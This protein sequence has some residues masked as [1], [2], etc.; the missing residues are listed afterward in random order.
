MKKSLILIFLSSFLAIEL[1]AASVSPQA[2]KTARLEVYQWIK[3][4]NTYAYCEG[5]MGAEKFME[6]FRDTGVKITNDYL[7]SYYNTA[8]VISVG[9]YMNL[10][11]NKNAFYK[12]Y[13]TITNSKIMKEDYQFGM[14]VYDVSFIKT[15]EFW[16]K[17]SDDENTIY[18][19]PQ[20]EFPLTV[21]LAYNVEKEKIYAIDIKSDTI[22][23]AVYVVHDES[24][25]FLNSYLA[26]EEAEKLKNKKRTKGN[27]SPIPEDPQMLVATKKSVGNVIFV[28]IGGGY[29]LQKFSMLK[30]DNLPLKL[31]N[32][33]TIAYNFN[34]GYRRELAFFGSSHC[35]S[36]EVGAEAY[37]RDFLLKANSNESEKMPVGKPFGSDVIPVDKYI[38]FDDQD[39]SYEH[40]VYIRSIKEQI[41]RYS[42]AIPINIRYDFYFGS[43]LSLFVRAGAL[44]SYDLL[45]ISTIKGD[46]RIIH[47]Y[48]QIA[49]GWRLGEQGESLIDGTGDFTSTSKTKQMNTD[50]K[51]FMNY[52][53]VEA[54]GGI[55]VQIFLAPQWSMDISAQYNYLLLSKLA[56]KKHQ[57]N[58]DV[59]SQ[60]DLWKDGNA[61]VRKHFN[62]YDPEKKEFHWSSLLNHTNKFN[63]QDI[64]LKIQFNYHF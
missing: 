30:N 21:K 10:M 15:V 32:D 16:Q 52:F 20:V 4:Y 59:P 12:M 55:G 19:Y 54:F 51:K 42:V 6:L 29:T 47:Y 56:D 7:P 11:L 39:L 63:S 53:A 43:N 41:Q 57:T 9:D 60:T 1:F 38:A 3:D 37:K 58:T 40:E 33:N 8:P 13:Y 18:A 46:G 24:S 26:R 25:L 44:A 49:G 31:S 64:Y 36:L 2:L 14:I 48:P 23:P 5:K 45:S 62:M 50:L 27:Y 17:S 28:G 35:L 61:Y 22:L 34:L